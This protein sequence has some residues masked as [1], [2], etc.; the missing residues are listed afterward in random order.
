M[1]IFSE[2][3]KHEKLER[4]FNLK[5]IPFL[6]KTIGILP[7]GLLEVLKSN[8]RIITAIE[9]Q[10]IEEAGSAEDGQFLFLDSG[11]A[12]NFYYDRTKEK[13]ITNHIYKKHDVIIDVNSFLNQI[14]R[15][16]NIQMLEQGTIISITYYSLRLLLTSFPELH[17]IQWHLQVE[18]EKQSLYYQYLLKL[19]LDERVKTY[20]EDNPGIATRINHN[21][22]ASYLGTCR[23]RFS[24]SYAKY[25][26]E[27]VE[28][29]KH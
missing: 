6:C 18:R 22:I 5:I 8:C 10:Y 15:K 7:H 16:G 21:H 23:S 13:Y 12:Q 9:Y 14:E 27:K 11:I 20:L 1:K 17:I 19:K 4:I 26:N 24:T 3:N 2:E 25:R 29:N 28:R